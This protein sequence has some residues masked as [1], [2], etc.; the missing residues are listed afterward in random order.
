MEIDTLLEGEV[1]DECADDNDHKAIYQ[2]R[3]VE[4]DEAY[5]DVVAL[6]DGDD[7]H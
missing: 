4:H 5:G 2:E 7:G 1:P 3:I 6:D